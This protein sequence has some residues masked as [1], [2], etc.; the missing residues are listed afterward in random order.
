MS[1]VDTP[2][3]PLHGELPILRG[4]R[5]GVA[6]PGQFARS[7]AAMFANLILAKRLKV[8]GRNQISQ[9]DCYNTAAAADTWR[10]RFR[11]SPNCLQVVA[12]HRLAPV[13]LQG[14]SAP[15][16]RIQWTTT[17]AGGASTAQ[18]EIRYSLRVTSSSTIVP[19]QYVYR[20]Q[21]WSLDPATTYEAVLNQADGLRVLGV[22]IYEITRSALSREGDECVDERGFA[23]GQGIYGDDSAD[24][25]SAIEAC[26]ADQGTHFVSWTVPSTTAKTTVSNSY[27]NLLNAATTT[28]G[29]NTEGWWAYPECH[30]LFHTLDVGAGRETVPIIVAAYM[31]ISN[32]GQTAS[33]ALC[34]DNHAPGAPITTLTRTGSTAGAW[35][36]QAV[37]W[38][39]P[40]SGPMKL[41]AYIKSTGGAT[42]SVRALAV[43]RG[44]TAS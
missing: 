28:P 31:S 42:A 21:V 40:S 9:A 33:L 8:L 12:R 39:A 32:A 22:Q 30:G 6:P 23:F 26:Y 13:D 7:N 25:F 10:K 20:N 2:N 35:V 34:D 3:V 36:A 11:T 44:A 5:N 43:Y 27:V 4:A 15:D 29:N 41:E 16:P 1:S 14:Q 37:D 24:L 19:D 38:S 17:I 18:P